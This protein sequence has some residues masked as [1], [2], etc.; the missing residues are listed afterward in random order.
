VE[1][2]GLAQTYWNQRIPSAW[3][4][5]FIIW[6]QRTWSLC[7]CVLGVSSSDHCK[8]TDSLT[9]LL[10]HICITSYL[11]ISYSKTVRVLWFPRLCRHSL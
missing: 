7:F 6:V 1:K 5:S 3:L 2:S 4:H 8:V 11:S 10:S 9:K